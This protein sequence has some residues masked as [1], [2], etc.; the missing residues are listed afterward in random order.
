MNPRPDLRFGS[1]KIVNFKLNF[2]S[3]RRFG[4][5]VQV[6]EPDRGISMKAAFAATFVGKAGGGDLRIRFS[7]LKVSIQ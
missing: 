3:V 5:S 2:G 1:A 4:G 6:H 7:D